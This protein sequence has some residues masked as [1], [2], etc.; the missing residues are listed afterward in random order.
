V[1]QKLVEGPEPVRLIDPTLEPNAGHIGVF[2]G[3]KATR[4]REAARLDL[5]ATE[6]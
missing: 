2:L 5:S 4:C 3:Q 6:P 1:R